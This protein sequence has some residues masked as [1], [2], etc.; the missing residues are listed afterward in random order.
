MKVLS[1]T[2]Y[3][4]AFLLTKLMGALGESPY[5]CLQPKVLCIMCKRMDSNDVSYPGEKYHVY[6]HIPH[7]W[8]ILY[9]DNTTIDTRYGATNNI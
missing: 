5:A 2:P 9:W 8:D 7:V 4:I 6:M 3:V 1:S